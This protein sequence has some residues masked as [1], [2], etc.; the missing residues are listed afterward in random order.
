M[1]TATKLLATFNT[2]VY[3]SLGFQSVEYGYTTI[4]FLFVPVVVISLALMI[5]K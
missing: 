1:N 4:L 5:R 3:T 2:I